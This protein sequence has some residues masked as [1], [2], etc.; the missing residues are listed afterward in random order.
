MWGAIRSL[1]DKGYE[2]LVVIT[3]EQASWERGV[4]GKNFGKAYIINVATYQRGVGYD[5]GYIHIN[6]F[7]DGVFDYMVE[8][9]R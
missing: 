3:D 7:S 8:I 4:D 2:R 1:K 9:E 5:N 6:G